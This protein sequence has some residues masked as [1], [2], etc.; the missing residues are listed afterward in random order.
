MNRLLP[1]WM[2]PQNSLFS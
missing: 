1:L 2:G